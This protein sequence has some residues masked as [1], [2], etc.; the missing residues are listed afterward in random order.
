MRKAKILATL[1]P[2]SDTPE[3]IKKLM[4]EGMNVVRL[5]M[6]HGDHDFHADM[7]KKIRSVCNDLNKEVGI[8]MDLQGPKIRVDKLPAPLNL[9]KAQKWAIGILK[10]KSE[11]Y[12]KNYIP[13][14][15]PN[16]VNDCKVGE[17]VLFDDGL[18][19]GIIVEK[20]EKV[21]VIEVTYGGILKSN[22]GINLPDTNISAPSFSDKDK[23]DLLFGL[24]NGID[25]VALS[26][27]RTA[28]DILDVKKLLHKY[29]KNIPVVA[30]IE[31]PE[32]IQN[33][34]EIIEATDIILI[35]R[36]DM[37]VELG[38]HLVPQV[39]KKIISKCN[40]R[41]KPVITATQ[42]LESMIENKSPTRAEANDVAN[43]VWDG[44][45]ILMLSGETA[46]GK[47]PIEAVRMMTKIIL[48]AEKSPKE[49]PLVRSMKIGSLS[50]TL[51]VAASLIS[52]KIQ[53]KWIITLTQSG[54]SA[55]K[56][57]R[58]RPQSGVLAVTRSL[59]VL[60]KMTILWGI[61][62]YLFEGKDENFE[63]LE[64]KMLDKLKGEKLIV[65]GEKVVITRGDG[66]MFNRSLSN[67][68]RVEIINNNNIN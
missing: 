1:G 51:Q 39:Q 43:A 28:K 64:F 23:N 29:R 60:R 44:S 53:A 25:F 36:G 66:S 38:N 65:E 13:T 54:N 45:D 37:A 40:L 68:I 22:K 8:L 26:F 41:G 52:E 61:T 10:D 58:F 12:K 14:V 55:I 56:M 30:K 33:I 32:A 5:N 2:S 63:E 11:E 48:E 42:M 20:K 18:L 27:V 57:S 59:N 24:K 9:S 19:E 31:K 15:Y 50:S 46:S 4:L 7:I 6:S 34:D 21:I 49:K 3:L 62:P 47:Y 35:A 67:T 16:L 17:R